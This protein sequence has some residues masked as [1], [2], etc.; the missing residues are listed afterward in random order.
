MNH[1]LEDAG[2]HVQA[3]GKV[4]TVIIAGE[5]AVASV[6]CRSALCLVDETHRAHL[7]A[8]KMGVVMFLSEKLI[9]S[10]C[11]Q[12]H[13]ILPLVLSNLLVFAPIR[14]IFLLLYVKNQVGMLLF[15]A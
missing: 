11:F 12:M 6:V 1:G 9:A 7:P 8:R 15:E 14:A 4:I 13:H 2:L 5:V 3:G 10:G